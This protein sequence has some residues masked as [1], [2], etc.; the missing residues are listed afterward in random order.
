M[1]YCSTENYKRIHG[2]KTND[3]FFQILNEKIFT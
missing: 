1:N 2:G 3:P